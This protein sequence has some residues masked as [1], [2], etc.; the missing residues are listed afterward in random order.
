MEADRI[1]IA[2]DSDILN[3][4]LFVFFPMDVGRIHMKNGFG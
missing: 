4:R 1:R 3:I 2:M